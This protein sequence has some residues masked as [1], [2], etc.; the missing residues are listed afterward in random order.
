MFKRAKHIPSKAFA[1]IAFIVALGVL[2]V[3][4]YA[5]SVISNNG[6]GITCASGG[7][8]CENLLNNSG[9]I[10]NSGTIN[11]TGNFTN[12]ATFVP[13]NGTVDLNGTGAQTI[14]GTANPALFYNL[15]ISGDK[16]GGTVNLLSSGTIGVA[17][18][19]N[20]S[21]TTVNYATN[22][23]DFDGTSAQSVPAF[24]YNNL[25][26][27]NN[28]GGGAVT[29]INGGTIGVAGIFN[30]S[31]TNVSYITTNNTID[32][33]GTS[34]QAIPA[35]NYNTLTISGNKGGGAVT[36]INGGIIGVAGSFNTTATNGSYTT[37]N[38]TID[39]NGS[40]AQTIPVFNYYSLSISNGGTKT[41][42]GA[43]T[44][45]A[46][47]ILTLNSGILEI[48]NYNLTI[49]NS[50]T[51]AIQGTFSSSCMIATDGTGYLIRNDATPLPI[52]YPIGSANT[53]NY[54]SP[55]SITALSGG[56]GGTINVRAVYGVLGL[57]FINTY[58]D[59]ITTAGGKTVTATLTND[60]AELNVVP[61]GFTAWYMPNGGIWQ[62]PPLA[63]GTFNWAANVLTI[64]G[65][66]DL[67]TSS[68]YWTA[69]K[70]TTFYSYQTGDWNASSTW[71]FDAGGTTPQFGNAIP[72]LDDYVVI[73]NG[74][75][76]SLSSDITTLN[77]NITINAGGFL[78]LTSHKYLNDLKS[79]SGQGTLKLGSTIADYFPVATTNTFVNSGGG[80]TEY[81]QPVT[82]TQS[83][84]NNLTINA[85]G[86]I[87]QTN[88]ITLNGNLLIKQGTFKINDGTAQRLQLIVKGNVTVNNTTSIT[89]GAGNTVT[90]ADAPL[91]V[92]AG[93]T[94]PF[95][96]YY[97]NETHSFVIYGNFIN[98]G[99][100]RFTNQAY[101][102]YNTFP[103]NG[104]V[105]VYFQGSTNN[106][107][108]CNGQTDFYNLVL[109]KGNDP[110]FSLTVYAPAYSNFKLFGANTAVFDVTGATNANPNIKKA[111]WVRNGTLDLTGLI[112]IPS[113]SE[114]ATAYP[115]TPTSDYFIPSNG[116]MIL[117]GQFVIVLATAD[118]YAEVNKAYSLSAPDNA[119]YGINTGGAGSGL[120]ILGNLQLNNGYLSTR[121]SS[122]LLYWS[123]ASGQFIM[124]GG[125]FDTKQFHNPEGGATG[126]VSYSQTGGNVIFRGRFINTINYPT[127]S[128]L[129]TPLISATRTSNGIDGTA[130]IGTLSINNN[131][132][133]GFTMSGG[134]ISIYD[135]CSTTGTDDAIYIGC[136]TSNI[137]V[138][139]GTVQVLPTTGS[140]PDEPYLINSTAPFWNFIINGTSTVVQLNTNPLVVL[141][142]LTL[143]TGTLDAQTQNLNVTIG[144]NFTING[145]TSYLYGTNTTTL[146]GSGTQ[147]FTINLAGALSVNNLTF[148]K[149]PGIAVN[150]AGS[151]T[152]INVLGN[153][154]LTLGTLNDNGDVIYVKQNVYNS[155]LHSGT[156]KISL[157]GT[158]AQTIDGNGTFQNLEL[159]NTNG[160]SGSAPVSL[161][162][163]T[164]VNGALTLLQDRLFNIGTYNLKLNASA[165]IING[166]TNRYIQ[167]A[168]N[169]GDGGI[170]K[171]YSST[172]P[173]TFP[174]GAPTLNPVLVTAYTPATISIS[175]APTTW[176]SITVTP[177][178]IEQPATTVKGTNL[179]YYWRVKNSGFTG[180]VHNSITHNYQYNTAD[181]LGNINNYVPAGM[182]RKLL[183]GQAVPI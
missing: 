168:G 82:I 51:N 40:A 139:G 43:T 146:N 96:N 124:K 119:T 75:T 99:T 179:T 115:T 171:V 154:N 151:Q 109:D 83:T 9:T 18:T 38:N 137:N 182:T 78:D 89:T 16:G 92:T 24:N 163:N 117:D 144:G 50:A 20:P 113:L 159:N 93:G 2:P 88:N 120:S 1:T 138:T 22:T 147:T 102:Q 76:V 148:T 172:T 12:N 122:G 162:A 56:T 61:A 143:Q 30:P 42:Q 107:L 29:L 52:S 48:G 140:M 180:L 65:T 47:G 46:S 130:G 73:L 5:Q 101:P 149:S 68:T 155:G 49:A 121:E 44:L 57:N 33:N 125:T 80:T 98:N 84:H 7:I 74:R 175:S 160:L 142:N 79:L 70:P 81:D 145:G 4:S 31:A 28:K 34:A 156:G 126:L 35:F 114:G 136:P 178:G 95:I 135:V 161:L 94:P 174:V 157:N 152:T 106:L 53:S 165:T 181:I 67:T 153:F 118:D 36:L 55:V 23:I 64:T 77:L 71:T 6:A 110:T 63:P 111:L 132:A 45:N 100:V 90:G 167:T 8:S 104:A 164:T 128:S 170:T 129:T 141:G 131:T 54:Y 150:L 59:I 86:T 166:G 116:A 13:G 19:F 158:I 169:S 69:G 26:I 85:A 123:Y 27:S 39:F 91:T 133:N 37:T 10:T 134:T 41:L 177:V 97:N 32:F 72:G 112:V 105:T 173:F 108:T 66:T 103:S 15:T 183:H 11:L 25:T 58:W 60:P 3:L 14:G 21:A 17:G 176:G 87:T 62:T 127:V